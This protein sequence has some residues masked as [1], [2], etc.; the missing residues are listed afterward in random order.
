MM[1]NQRNIKGELGNSYAGTAKKTLVTKETLANKFAALQIEDK[2]EEGHEEP[3][4][5]KPPLE[6]KGKNLVN[7]NKKID[8]GFLLQ[9]LDNLLETLVLFESDKTRKVRG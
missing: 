1:V 3:L 9:G 5:E 6:N 8:T 7:N 4:R 2:M